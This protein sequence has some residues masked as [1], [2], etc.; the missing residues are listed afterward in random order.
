MD[1]Q[2]KFV[3]R[4]NIVEEIIEKWPYIQLFEIYGIRSVGKSRLANHLLKQLQELKLMTSNAVWVDLKNCVQIKDAFW[5]ILMR[6]E[7]VDQGYNAKF[8]AEKVKSKVQSSPSSF[9]IVFDNA[10]DI[11]DN[12]LEDV[13]VSICAIM[14]ENKQI[15]IIVTSTTYLNF[16]ETS[17]KYRIDL[18]F[19]TEAEALELMKSAA[20]SV[21][22]GPYAKDIVSSCTGLPLAL[23]IVASELEQ[24]ASKLLT[25]AD[26]VELLMKCRVK[27]LSD[28]M[29]PSEDQI[30]Y[31]YL[32]FIRRLS[33]RLQ[34]DLTVLNYIPGSFNIQQATEILGQS[35]EEEVAEEIILPIARRHMVE[36]TDVNGRFD[37]HGMLR[38]CLSEY[39]VIRNL[40]EIR[41]RF[42]RI[43][44]ELLIK[45][46]DKF[47]TNRFQEAVICFNLERQNFRK[48]F[49]DVL[50]STDETYP[51]FIHV[52]MSATENILHY[53]IGSE[54]LCFFDHC[55]TLT[56]NFKRRRDEAY[57]HKAY[58]SA[59]TNVI[60]NLVKGEKHYRKA[61]DILLETKTR[62]YHLAETYQ[63]I[64][65]NLGI[66][67]KTVD[68]LGCLEKAM[69]IE[70]ELGMTLE[71]LIL[72]TIASKAIFTTH[73][74]DFK[75]A[76]KL[77][78]ENLRRRRL[79]FKTDNH[80]YIGS[81]MNNIG[82]MY[83][84]MG[85]M[86]EAYKYFREGLDIKKATNANEK[87][88]IISQKNVAHCLTRMGRY[89]EAMMEMNEAM[90]MLEKFPGLYEEARA[91][92][93]D[94][95]ARIYMHMRDYHRAIPMLKQAIKIR[96]DLSPENINT[97]ENI[98]LY[99][100][101]C[102]HLA[103]YS[104]AKENIEKVLEMQPRL[105]KTHPREFCV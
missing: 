96:K 68:A 71:N 1:I 95:K 67:G 32:S 79:V 13:F 25:P 48:L 76:E 49:K 24:D 66:Q 36:S 92:V 10:E 98:V 85:N 42:C 54:G 18:P 28:P 4:E 51:M 5:P 30:G 15:K 81:V 14:L 100:K 103:K 61:L 22:F 52:A 90:K 57:I 3:G 75:E 23:L 47:E 56:Q 17:A 70:T 35:S 27:V 91:I 20:P 50:H 83:E 82:L 31:V 6:L 38:D 87:A 37:I 69:E 64:G 63:R 7:L 104:E 89:D 53:C 40:P 94:G 55:L 99:A 59:F 9:V 8:L 29:F 74:W 97:V 102:F 46:H 105:S 39:I 62:D 44:S 77:H 58:G 65:W 45:M 21:D 84:R 16:E 11:L 73:L 88:I 101:A 41:K 19:L 34:Q 26:M 78:F 86:D 33:E 43:F 60:G 93:T 72:Q 2:H 80:P 12:G